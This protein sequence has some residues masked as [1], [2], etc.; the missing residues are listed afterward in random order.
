MVIGHDGETALT[1]QAIEDVRNRIGDEYPAK[2]WWH[3]ATADAI[4]HFAEGYGDANPLYTDPGYGRTTKYN[5]QLAPPTFLYCVMS[6]G[7]STGGVGLPGAFALHGEDEWEWYR[8]IPEGTRLRGVQKLT[9]VEEKD[10]K[11]AGRVVHQVLSTEFF[12]DNEEALAVYRA[13][14]VRGD[15]IAARSSGKYEPTARSTPYYTD[16]MLELISAGYD[17][18]T[19]RGREPRYWEDVNVGDS[20]GHVV[21]GPLAVRDIICWW[22][23]RGAPLLKAFRHWHDYVAK[24]PGIAIIDPDTNIRDS[25]ETAHYDEKLARRSGVAA[26]YDIGTLRTSWC[27]HLLTNWCGDDGSLRTMRVRF[28]LPNYVG[29]TSW[30]RGT[31]V[32]K[33]VLD[34]AHLVDCAM[35]IRNE[36]DELHT[37]ATATVEL[38]SRASSHP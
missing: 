11:W 26:P 33:S 17:A 5:S 13:R 8:P 1:P 21:K 2:A 24:R 18:E 29:S 9:S 12:G 32:G 30:V 37:S 31:V 3:V 6:A 14:V 38:P 27:Q 19:I 28:F 25:P 20:L 23:G 22:I 16:G 36:Q 10:S 15:R 4:K 7:G 35:E 34:G